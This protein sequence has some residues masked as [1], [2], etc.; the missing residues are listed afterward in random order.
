MGRSSRTSRPRAPSAAHSSYPRGLFLDNLSF[1]A[2]EPQRLGRF[3]EAALGG[4]EGGLHFDI[5]ARNSDTEL[6][7]PKGVGQAP[8]APEK[9]VPVSTAV[10]EPVRAQIPTREAPGFFAQLIGFFR[11]LFGLEILN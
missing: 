8:V 7:S 10:S 6:V 11:K 9:T 3:W 5:P 4:E 1:D 2:A